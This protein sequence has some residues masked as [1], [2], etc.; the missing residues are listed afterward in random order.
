MP[1][2]KTQDPYDTVFN[3][4]FASQK[5]AK[6]GDK[7]KGEGLKMPEVSGLGGAFAEIAMSPVLYPIENIAGSMGDEMNNLAAIDWHVYGTSGYGDQYGSQRAG[8]GGVGDVDDVRVRVRPNEIGNFVT[9]PRGYINKAV[10]KYKASKKWARF[11]AITRAMSAAQFGIWAKKALKGTNSEH[12]AGMVAQTMNGGNGIL[13]DSLLNDSKLLQSSHNLIAEEVTQ[14]Y[15]VNKK[16]VDKAVHEGMGFDKKADRLQATKDVLASNGVHGSHANKIAS[17]YWGKNSDPDDLGLYGEDM[18]SVAK[19]ELIDRLRTEKSRLAASTDPAKR[20]QAQKIDQLITGIDSL[21]GSW[22]MKGGSVVLGQLVGKLGFSIKWFNENIKSGMAFATMVNGAMFSEGLGDH[23]FGLLQGYE[24]DV[25]DD[26]GNIIG[27]E[28]FLGAR[29]SNP[30]SSVVGGLQY[31]HP[32]N[33]LKGIAWDGRIYK[34]LA[35][36]MG[37]GAIDYSNAGSKMFHQLYKIMPA[38][39][40]RQLLGRGLKKLHQK[41]IQKVKKVI[42]KKIAQAFGKTL[43]MTAQQL[44]GLPLKA[45]ISKIISTVLTQLLGSIVPGIGNIAALLADVI[46]W[47]GS[48]FM[49][50][51]IKPILQFIALIFMGVLAMIVITI[52]G[53][54]AFLGGIRSSHHV[55]RHLNPPYTGRGGSGDDAGPVDWADDSDP[56][57]TTCGCPVRGSTPCTQGSHGLLPDK[58]GRVSTYHQVRRAVD[59]GLPGGTPIGMSCPGE[60]TFAN[61]HNYCGGTGPDYG[62]K[63]VFVDEN[64]YEWTFLHIQP[65]V[66]AGTSFDDSGGVLGTVSGHA[67]ASES[68]CWTGPHIHIHVADPSGANVDSEV[69]LQEIGCSFN[70]HP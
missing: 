55:Q 26:A 1:S 27:Q 69:F 36:K 18:R 16:L 11:G 5:K 68:D 10:D 22:G 4:V 33:F 66:S 19:N 15:G 70:C 21:G 17:R 24:V 59:F 37:G 64:G 32:A 50:K 62:G 60:V 25:L 48:L 6:K 47:I 56:G 40:L 28:R 58:S 8:V 53:F 41:T 54:G 65:E 3:F 7:K 31:A 13:S 61:S 44:A 52:G 67:D 14:K 12:L 49:D 57:D 29:G 30:I 34:L 9:D 23:V 46:V 20:R 35:K 42:A 39:Q 2:K 63:I 51:L 45:F 43:R 38:T